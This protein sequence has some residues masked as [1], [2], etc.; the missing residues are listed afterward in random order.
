MQKVSGS[1]RPLQNPLLRRI[2]ALCVDALRVLPARLPIFMICL[3]QGFPAFTLAALLRLEGHPHLEVFAKAPAFPSGTDA[4]G[5]RRY[6][7]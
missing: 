2:S 6:Y 7:S 3:S 5:K 1:L 4:G